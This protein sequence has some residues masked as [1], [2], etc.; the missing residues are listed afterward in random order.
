MTLLLVRSTS[1]ASVVILRHLTLSLSDHR[2][3][4]YGGQMQWSIP[5]SCQSVL[6]NARSEMVYLSIP[7]G[8]GYERCCI[9]LAK[10]KLN[11]IF[12]LS[13]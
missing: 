6:F 8:S 1:I 7:P 2:V 12:W 9:I 5:E 4:E 10:E 13:S 3:Q 11:N